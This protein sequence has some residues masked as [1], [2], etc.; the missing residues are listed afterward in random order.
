MSSPLRAEALVAASV[1]VGI[2]QR[3]RTVFENSPD[4]QVIFDLHTQAPLEFN[5]AAL[6]LLQ[7]G[8]EELRRAPL[9]NH[10]APG[11]RPAFMAQASQVLLLGR[12][13]FE[14]QMRRQDGSIIDVQVRAAAVELEGRSCVHAVLRDVT[15]T[16]R[17]A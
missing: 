15:A 13:D 12:H 6:R 17:A 16:N 3:Y 2:E 8:A 7:T 11:D 14:C 4:A 1:L 5:A 10:L 9:D